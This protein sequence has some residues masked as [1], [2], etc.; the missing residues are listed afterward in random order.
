MA[1]YALVQDG[2]VQQVVVVPDDDLSSISREPGL[3]VQTSYNTQGGVHILGGVPL[4]KNYAGIGFIYDSEL[5]AFYSPRPDNLHELDVDSCTWR[6][7][8]QYADLFYVHGVVDVIP[9]ISQLDGHLGLRVLVISGDSCGLY[10]SDGEKFEFIECKNRPISDISDLD[11]NHYWTL[12][13]GTW[14]RIQVS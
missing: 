12:Q 13:D 1:H 14:T 5:D 6:L 4:R 10:Q 11:P 9:D 7:K 2:I 3:W 8:T